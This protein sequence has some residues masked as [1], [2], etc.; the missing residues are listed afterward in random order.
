[1]RPFE[2]DESHLFFG[3]DD[4]VDTLI[5]RLARTRFLAVLGSSGTGKS[6]LVRTG[7]LSGL[8]M[9]LLRGAGA[10]WRIVDF[11]PGAAPL[12]NL[13]RRLLETDAG[14]DR[15]VDPG[16]VE[17][18]RSQL[19]QDGPR[20]LIEWCRGGR[21]ARGT[22]LL[23]LVDQ[24]EELFRYQGYAGR[25]AAE[26]LVS[27]LLESRRPIEVDSPQLAEFPIYV[28]ITMRSE[29][30]GACALIEGLAEAINEGTYLTPRMTRQECREAIV[31]PARVCGVE[32]EDLLVTRILNDLANFAP[33]EEAE[34]GDQLSRLARRA[35]QL[36]LMQHALNRMWQRARGRQ[37]AGAKV[38]LTAHD[39]RGLEKELDEHADQV[40]N[41]LGETARPV[42]ETIFRAVTS[43]TTVANAV[44]RPTRYD[45]LVAICGGKNMRRAVADVLAA[46]GPSGCHFLTSDIRPNGPQ[47]PDDAIIDISHESLIRQWKEL[48]G[49]LRKEGQAAHEWQRLDEEAK[50][51]LGSDQ[52]RRGELL[53]GA[54]LL[55]AKAL[56]QETRA[57][58]AWAGR[59]GVD[60]AQVNRFI[61][62]SLRSVAA[63]QALRFV[64]AC[65]VAAASIYVVYLLGENAREHQL[66]T[67]LNDQVN[68]NATY[69]DS[70]LGQG[71]EIEQLAVDQLKSY[72]QSRRAMLGVGGAQRAN[73]ND[74]LRDFQARY[75]DLAGLFSAIERVFD[76]ARVQEGGNADLIRPHLVTL[77]LLSLLRSDP[78]SDEAVQ[79]R[80]KAYEL[81]DQLAASEMHLGIEGV[82][83]ISV[84]LS[85]LALVL[86]DDR[87]YPEAAEALDKVIPVVRNFIA[88]RD[89]GQD[90]D[91]TART[92]L[93]DIWRIKCGLMADDGKLETAIESCSEALEAGKALPPDRNGER[94]VNLHDRL[95]HVYALRAQQLAADG[96]NVAAL[97]QA[98][99]IREK[100]ILQL[101]EAIQLSDND[102][103]S[104]FDRYL[105]VATAHTDAWRAAL[106][107]IPNW[108]ST[109]E[110]RINSWL[111]EENPAL[112]L[113]RSDLVAQRLDALAGLY[114]G[115]GKIAEARV[116]YLMEISVRYNLSLRDE[117]ER[118]RAARGQIEESSNAGTEA[119]RKA[120]DDLRTSQGDL[121]KYDFDAARV[122]LARALEHLGRVD[123]DLPRR[124][125][126]IREQAGAQQLFRLCIEQLEPLAD[127]GGAALRDR[128]GMASCYG[129]WAWVESQRSAACLSRFVSATVKAETCSKET[130]LELLA[131]AR[132]AYLKSADYLQKAFDGNTF[133][134]S[135]DLTSKLAMA[136]NTIVEMEKLRAPAND[137]DGR[138]KA[139]SAA[140]PHRKRAV[141]VAE[142]AYAHCRE[143]GSDVGCD[144]SRVVDDLE[145]RKIDYAR[146]LIQLGMAR[147]ARLALV[148]AIA[149]R[150]RDVLKPKSHN[151][152]LLT[153]NLA[154]T[155]MFSGEFEAAK[156]IYLAVKDASFGDAEIPSGAGNIKA[157]FVDLVAAGVVDPAMC[158]IGKLLN[159][160]NY[161]NVTCPAMAPPSGSAQ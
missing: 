9:G 38:A 41:D 84:S 33:W 47:L 115:S 149:L 121:R 57:T 19:A 54:R 3:R 82:R 154:H 113:T 55:N 58:P 73:S 13:A 157:D 64:L 123:G 63:W 151:E 150:P 25:E 119:E 21:L 61:D 70:V 103:G 18:L 20:A 122:S 8:E 104:R 129:G 81:V 62:K 30:L 146:S 105:A 106:G 27:L 40:L 94:L 160:E 135:S 49:W 134:V 26:A 159:D 14:R 107:D 131:S 2:R 86:S 108:V 78:Y 91:N 114:N 117:I 45:E 34:A 95:S 144:D 99:E 161:A 83:S 71:R 35:D 50:H 140:V 102:F 98:A 42:A 11:R 128:M 46:F 137:P 12:A 39:Y 110:F 152:L 116:S 17:R 130:R 89:K 43:G 145:V 147:E 79:Q 112:A 126:E 22:N 75:K 155:L 10:R 156:K 51:Y 101:R 138:R 127:R 5:E 158:Q 56:R 93:V 23:L 65:A 118:A 90:A 92:W 60:L 24:F 96:G 16:E 132:D 111:A 31:G 76:T 28:T 143:A 80:Q 88:E 66:N 133:A 6:S 52:P 109:N 136:A 120:A 48:S 68:R 37:V 87:K 125:G 29:Y 148:S 85:S 97:R 59:I 124:E 141:D 100:A 69:R 15:P 67:Q 36:P 32:I 1:L 74:K 153:L 142:A 7:L 72:A 77:A 44:R 4:C 139:V 53:S